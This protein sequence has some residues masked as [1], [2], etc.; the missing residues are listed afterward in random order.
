MRTVDIDS[1]ARKEHYRLFRQFAQPH[2]NMCAS[3][4]VSSFYPAMKASGV[5]LTV[6][7]VYLIARTANAIPEFRYRLRP[8][9]VIEHEVVH[10]SATILTGAELFSFCKMPY[11]EN[12]ALFHTSAL[13]RI[14]YVNAHLNLTDESDTDDL[15][16]MTSLPWVSFTSFTHPL[17]TDPPDS[18]PRFAWGKITQEGDRWKMP[19]S[20]Q[21]HHA[22]MDGL[23]MAR[24]YALIQEGFDQPDFLS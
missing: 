17:P 6:A 10:P 7:I 24:Y 23:H 9:G 3:M 4:D 20:V 11:C 13:E 18:V 2:F 19:L 1:W 5:S 14:A 22:L 16:F 12:F 21:A 15:L 8:E